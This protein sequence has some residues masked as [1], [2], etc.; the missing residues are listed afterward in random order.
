MAELNFR[1]ARPPC[2]DFTQGYN[3][4]SPGSAGPAGLENLIHPQ[5]H[6]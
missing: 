4:T 1:I 2:I 6:P 5:C 3:W